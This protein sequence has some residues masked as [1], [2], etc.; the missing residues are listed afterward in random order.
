MKHHKP[1]A[2]W[3]FRQQL[4]IG[5]AVTVAAGTLSASPVQAAGTTSRDFLPPIATINARLVEQAVTSTDDPL[6]PVALSAVQTPVL[7]ATPKVE[8][9]D[10][11]LSAQ[12]KATQVENLIEIQ[13]KIDEADLESLWEATVEK[14][15]VIRFSLEKLATPADL[16]NK[17]SSRFMTKTLNMLIS[18]ATMVPAMLP[19]SG[20]YQ[21]MGS[22]AVGNALQNLVNG[23]TQ[24]NPNSLSATEQIQLAGLIDQ[25][26]LRL[27]H[28]YQDYKNTLQN[29]AQS[30]AITTK[31]NLLYSKA[32]ASKN[33]LAIMAAGSA[34]YQSLL[35]ETALRQ[36]AKLNRLQLERLAGPEAVQ[37]LELAVH[38]PESAAT[39]LSTPT[40]E[41][42]SLNIKELKREEFIGPSPMESVLQSSTA[43][44]GELIG[45]ELPPAKVR[46]PKQNTR[47]KPQNNEPLQPMEIGP[48]LNESDAHHTL[49]LPK[50]ISLIEDHAQTGE[51]GLQ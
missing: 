51:I 15:P 23:K 24:I 19:G 13:R 34:Y 39:A 35:S 30:H 46:M 8:M 9:L 36:K 48:Q 1:S 26:K 25:L 49:E 28:N 50:A 5:L 11:D 6:E 2:S 22:M 10:T 12:I 40:I 31:N 21:N 42:A 43:K 14:N 33:D 32:L 3:A 16:Q 45:P 37:R 38:V 41:P 47:K 18:G 20:M 29:L 44:T 17:Q 4:A 27:I 7:H